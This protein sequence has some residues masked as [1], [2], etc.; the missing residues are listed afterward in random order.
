MRD[1]E[2]YPVEVTGI[3][4]DQTILSL[5]AFQMRYKDDVLT[6]WGH[7]APTSFTYITTKKKVNEIYC[8][9]AFPVTAQEQ[10]E[11]DAFRAFLQGLSNAGVIIE[12]P[13]ESQL[14]QPGFIDTSEVGTLPLP[15]VSTSTSGIGQGTLAGAENATSTVAGRLTASVIASSKKIGTFLAALFMWPWNWAKA[16]FGGNDEIECAP[17]SIF[18]NWFNWILV[19]IILTMGYLWLRE[20]REAKKA[21]K[22][23]EELEL[24]N[25]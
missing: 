2:G 20:R 17:T 8:K 15:G 23:N 21:A 14:N 18:S 7:T 19:I 24:L 11:I 12:A 9:M 5:N 1:L 6:P 22:L 25:K 4:D 3:Y 13:T 10:S 16:W